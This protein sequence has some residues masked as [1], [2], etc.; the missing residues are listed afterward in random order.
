M[1]GDLDVF[2]G[3]QDAPGDLLFFG[4]GVIRRYQAALFF[5]E[6]QIVGCTDENGVVVVLL[7]EVA[8][9]V[10]A[11]LHRLFELGSGH[12][13]LDLVPSFYYVIWSDQPGLLM[14][15]CVC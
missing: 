8:E 12:E 15:L 9:K 6:H 14:D 10:N 1:P 13:M 7:V 5:I 3:L 4:H 2:D 11:P